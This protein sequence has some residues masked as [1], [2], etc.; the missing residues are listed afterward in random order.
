MENVGNENVVGRVDDERTILDVTADA[1]K[2]QETDPRLHDHFLF[3]L[4]KQLVLL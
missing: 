3:I 4:S 2:R 1:Q